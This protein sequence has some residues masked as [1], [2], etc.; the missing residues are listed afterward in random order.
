MDAATRLDY[1]A[2]YMFVTSQAAAGGKAALLVSKDGSPFQPVDL[3]YIPLAQVRQRSVPP[4]GPCSAV[5]CSAVQCSAVQCSARQPPRGSAL[6]SGQCSAGVHG[7]GEHSRLCVPADERHGRRVR[8]EHERHRVLPLGVGRAV[9]HALLR[10]PP[11]RCNTPTGNLQHGLATWQRCNNTQM[12]RTHWQ[13]CDSS[14]EHCGKGRTA[15]AQVA[16]PPRP[17]YAGS[18]ELIGT[19][20]YSGPK[21]VTDGWQTVLWYVAGARRGRRAHRERR[22]PSQHRRG[23][24]ARDQNRHFLRQRRHMAGCVRASSASDP[25]RL[26]LVDFDGAAPLWAV[27]D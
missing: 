26:R 24:Q 17:G 1:A 2:P 20:R 7:A 11:G 15:F 14:T 5:Q 18:A 19:D 4:C 6:H 9:L 22:R 25:N 16:L 10:L 8:V 23:W 12:H 21:A 3:S 27:P 13:R